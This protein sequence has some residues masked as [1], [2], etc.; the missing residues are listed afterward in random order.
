MVAAIIIIVVMRIRDRIKKK[1]K[2]VYTSE[3]D[4]TRA[5]KDIEKLANA[6]GGA[7]TD[8]DEE[9]DD[10]ISGGG[11]DADD[12]HQTQTVT[13]APATNEQ[14]SESEEQ[15]TSA[16]SKKADTDLND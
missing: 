15:P 7:K 10:E 5:F 2:T 13:E 6:D 12:E 16:Q 8:R 14:L 11:D 3:Y 1:K 4:R 9:L